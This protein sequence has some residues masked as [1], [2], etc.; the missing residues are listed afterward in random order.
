MILLWSIIE[1]K[2]LLH[3]N[4]DHEYLKK[5]TI[6]ILKNIMRQFILVNTIQI[7][8]WFINNFQRKF[9]RFYKRKLF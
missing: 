8:L 3:M 4:N 7:G 1:M 5:V 9:N 6:G 2:K